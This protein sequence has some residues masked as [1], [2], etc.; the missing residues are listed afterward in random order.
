MDWVLFLF[1]NRR[2]AIAKNTTKRIERKEPT[3]IKTTGT[4]ETVSAVLAVV[5]GDVVEASLFIFKLR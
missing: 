3:Q 5:A 2:I 1:W 4:G